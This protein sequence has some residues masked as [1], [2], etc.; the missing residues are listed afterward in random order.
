MTKKARTQ[1]VLQSWSKGSENDKEAYLRKKQQRKVTTKRI[2]DELQIF[3]AVI[4]PIEGEL[5]S[6]V[7]GSTLSSTSLR[8]G[9]SSL[10]YL[11]DFSLAPLKTRNGVDIRAQLKTG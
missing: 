5:G 6:Q 1:D 10:M 7:D 3:S 4:S 9:Y 11:Q 8:G 2:R